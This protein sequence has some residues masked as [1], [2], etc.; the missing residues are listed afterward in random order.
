MYT[1]TYISTHSTYYKCVVYMYVYTYISSHR[2]GMTV[3]AGGRRGGGLDRRIGRA[4]GP[5][6]MFFNGRALAPETSAYLGT[7]SPYEPTERTEFI[8]IHE[9]ISL[10]PNQP[11]RAR[12]SRGAA[13]VRDPPPTERGIFFFEDTEYPLA[14]EGTA[15]V[16]FRL[17]ASRAA[18]FELV[19]ISQNRADRFRASSFLYTGII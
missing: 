6:K 1:Y 7:V 10:F 5:I 18:N 12:R 15:H 3:R 16:F 9:Y 13:I 17:R 8:C 19:G 2:L 14:N 11:I 4:R